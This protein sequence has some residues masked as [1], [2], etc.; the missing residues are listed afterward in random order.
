VLVTHDARAGA[1]ADRTLT[2]VEGRLQAAR[3]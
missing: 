2:L 1:M 3:G